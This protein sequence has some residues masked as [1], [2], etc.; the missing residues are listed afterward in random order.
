MYSI[1]F[2]KKTLVQEICNWS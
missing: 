2:E 1:N